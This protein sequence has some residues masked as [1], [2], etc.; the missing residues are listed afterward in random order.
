VEESEGLNWSLKAQK[1]RKKM[2]KKFK[3]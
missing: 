3:H 1:E 2:W